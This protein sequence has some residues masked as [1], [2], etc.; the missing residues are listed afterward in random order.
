M[1]NENLAQNLESVFQD[2]AFLKQVLE[3]SDV[4]DVQKMLEDR[5]VEM[6]TDQITAFGEILSKYEAGEITQEQL[7][8][9]G[10]DE[11]SDDDLE[12]VAGGFGDLMTVINGVETVIKVGAIAVTAAIGLGATINACVRR[13]GW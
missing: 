10:S 2:E 1:N 4:T 12:N 13:S 8:K 5:G 7:E 11:L 9:I 3:A 6:T